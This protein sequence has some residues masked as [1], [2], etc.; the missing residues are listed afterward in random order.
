VKT[1]ASTPGS[2]SIFKI[3][4]N[5]Y[6]ASSHTATHGKLSKQAAKGVKVIKVADLP[7]A[8]LPNGLTVLNP[9]TGILLVANSAKGL[10]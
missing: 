6:A 1:F 7:S 3:D 5:G 8:G 9:N 4:L 2:Y 10:V